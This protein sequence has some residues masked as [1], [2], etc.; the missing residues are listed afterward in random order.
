MT[1]SSNWCHCLWHTYT[2]NTVVWLICCNFH[3]WE[4]GFPRWIHFCHLAGAEAESSHTLRPRSKSSLHKVLKSANWQW[5]SDKGC[6]A[7]G[8]WYLWVPLCFRSGTH[9]GRK[10]NKG[11][12]KWTATNVN[13]S[14][15]LDKRKDNSPLKKRQFPNGDTGSW[16][17][18][19][20]DQ[21]SAAFWKPLWVPLLMNM[22]ASSQC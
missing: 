21:S 15:H 6:M 2:V 1:I 16:P 8:N 11:N 12:I 5:F 3:P 18:F 10:Q 4:S 19:I 7:E 14:W 13:H 22:K 17:Q 20:T 9:T